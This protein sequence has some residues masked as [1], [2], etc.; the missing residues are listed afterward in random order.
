[1]PLGADEEL[2]MLVV[3][4]KGFFR[5]AQYS[6]HSVEYRRDI[7]PNEVFLKKLADKG[8]D[9]FTFI[10]RK[11]ASTTPLVPEKSWAKT[12]DN[13]GLLVVKTYDEWLTLI[14]K[15]TRNMIRK[16]EKSG[17]KTEVVE[18]SEKLA[19]SIEKIFNESPIRQGRAFPQYGTT[20]EQV[21]SM[22]FFDP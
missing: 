21:R 9:V 7:V 16:A 2:K 8:V 20:L 11:W 3:R 19:E 4:R 18:P 5:L 6:S 1:M 10:D 15:K 13:I 14:G 22:V 12:M 17:V